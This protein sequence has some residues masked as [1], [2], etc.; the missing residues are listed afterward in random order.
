MTRSHGSISSMGAL[1]DYS[2]SSDFLKTPPP[3]SPRSPAVF[4]FDDS[5]ASSESS[6]SSVEDDCGAALTEE[7]A[8]SPAVML[9]LQA[10]RTLQDFV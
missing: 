2:D 9:I 1:S 10:G 6:Q 8:L 5:P 7:A 4:Q 3:C